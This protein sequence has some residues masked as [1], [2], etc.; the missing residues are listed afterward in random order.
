MGILRTAERAMKEK[1]LRKN[2]ASKNWL[3]RSLVFSVTVPKFEIGDVPLAHP[4]TGY[5]SYGIAPS[6]E[7]KTAKNRTL[8][9][10]RDTLEW[11]EY[12]DL[13]IGGLSLGFRP[14]E[15]CFTTITQI[16]LYAVVSVVPVNV[17]RVIILL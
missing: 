14:K 8:F 2:K 15:I 12:F 11:R 4:P 10:W 7:I 17:V 16:R 3:T 5:A 9:Y 1:V 13:C 6:G